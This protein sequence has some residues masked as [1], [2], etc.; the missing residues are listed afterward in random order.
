MQRPDTLAWMLAKA[1]E[2][3][4]NADR[5]QRQFLSAN[6]GDQLA[7]WEPSVDMVASP[8]GVR[9]IVALPGVASDR[10]E[11]ALDECKVVVRGERRFGAGLFA[12]E[13]L[14]LEIPYGRFER[15]IGLPYGSYRMADM[16]LEGG[17]LRLDLE[18]IS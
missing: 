12:G 5:L 18:R 2:Q 11:V 14:R 17:C 8:Y 7:S 3:L 15:Q 6:Q 9:L 16:Q 10:L 13:I 1:V 4:E